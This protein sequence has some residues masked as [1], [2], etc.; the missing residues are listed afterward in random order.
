MEIIKNIVTIEILFHAPYIMENT[1]LIL[2]IFTFFF[3]F[4]RCVSR[5]R[6][7]ICDLFTNRVQYCYFS[8][9]ISNFFWW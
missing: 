5:K 1:V 4:I 8:I 3:F 6:M 7:K 9:P 2:N